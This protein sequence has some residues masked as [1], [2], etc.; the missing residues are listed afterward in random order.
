MGISNTSRLSI[1]EIMNS[2]SVLVDIIETKYSV[3]VYVDIAGVELS[4][5]DIEFHTHNIL[6]LITRQK[7]YN[8]IVKDIQLPIGVTCKE[9]LD[10]NI[11]CGVITIIIPRPMLSINIHE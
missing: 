5:I 10:I 3:I 6:R 1:C 9:E 2:E 11:G 4:F 8:F 7:G